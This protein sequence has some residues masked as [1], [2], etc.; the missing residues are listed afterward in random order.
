MFC[1]FQ[2]CK[3]RQCFLL[4][5]TM[6]VT[7]Q[8]CFFRLP[9]HAAKHRDA[10][11]DSTNN[12]KRKP[13]SNTNPDWSQVFCREHFC[14]TDTKDLVKLGVLVQFTKLLLGTL[15]ESPGSVFASGIVVVGCVPLVTCEVLDLSVSTGCSDGVVIVGLGASEEKAQVFTKLTAQ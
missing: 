5:W 11:T 3:G 2:F 10:S 15:P 1:I 8:N 14:T 13:C 7:K 12:E 6:S 9:F 4:G